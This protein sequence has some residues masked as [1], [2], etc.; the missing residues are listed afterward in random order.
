M[1]LYKLGFVCCLMMIVIL[2]VFVIVIVIVIVFETKT[3]ETFAYRSCALMLH[4][5]HRK[6]SIF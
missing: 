4:V 6:N 2:L 5:H 3:V 1:V